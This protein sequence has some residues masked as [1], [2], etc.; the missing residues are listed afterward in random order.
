[1]HN[2]ETSA[3][4][5]IKLFMV[6]R[7]KKKLKNTRVEKSAKEREGQH[8]EEDITGVVVTKQNVL[9]SKEGMAF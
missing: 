6:T 2:S 8:I 4:L 1:M 7:F 3:I 9:V 5:C